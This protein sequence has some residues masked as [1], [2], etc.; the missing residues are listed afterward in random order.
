MSADLA[1]TGASPAVADLFV[2]EHTSS[3]SRVFALVYEDGRRPTLNAVLTC[4]DPQL[5]TDV[6]TILTAAAKGGP[7][8]AVRAEIDRLAALLPAA[9]AASLRQAA[10]HTLAGRWPASAPSRSTNA[11]DNED[12]DRPPPGIADE[13]I[14]TPAD[15]RLAELT[16][17]V[18]RVFHLLELHVH[19]RDR[20]VTAAAAH[21]WEPEE[22]TDP[23]DLDNLLDAVMWL[24]EMD[25]DVPGTDMVT[26][27]A[28][29]ELLRAEDGDEVCDW[30]P[31][32][33]TAT[34]GSGWR[35]T[36]GPGRSEDRPDFAS[37]YDPAVEE[38]WPLTPRTA[39]LL[40]SKL[41]D[42][43]DAGRVDLDEHAGQPVE[44]S[45][46][47]KW[48]LFG[49]LPRLSWRQDLLWRKQVVRAFD[50]LAADLRAG[51]YLVPRCNAEE[52]VLHLAINGAQED[53]DLMPE[54]LP[55]AAQ[56]LPQH[57]NDFDLDACADA[58]FQ[59]HDILLL[60]RAELDGIEDP[61]DDGNRYYGI[62]SLK[63]EDWFEPFL[64]V[65]PRDP[66][67]GFVD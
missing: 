11:T 6:A 21:G 23:L 45:S 12:D 59:D 36:E 51:D 35:L 42:L 2:C 49:Q 53:L 27:A 19:D 41:R 31:T 48:A 10:E 40:Y 5:A 7:G 3:K 63:P 62:G 4:T 9:P 29:G 15:A 14:R 8:P 50:D 24:A 13:L 25:P 64:N 17:P 37:L 66:D 20:L 38:N 46:R 26:D 61:A 32:T 22:G 16:G 39:A 54:L 65:E 30:S 28:H 67:R 56:D 58:L 18:V 1:R 47:G 55:E 34:F 43:A 52:L 33:V 44:A 57:E 60:Y